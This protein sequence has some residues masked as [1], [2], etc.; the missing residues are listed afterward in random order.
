MA[1]GTRR[2]QHDSEL[3]SCYH[4]AFLPW[5]SYHNNIVLFY[6]DSPIT[7]S[8]FMDLT[9]RAIKSFY[10]ISGYCDCWHCHM[11]LLLKVL[12]VL[13]SKRYN[14]N[15]LL[16]VTSIHLL[17]VSWNIIPGQFPL[18]VSK[19]IKIVWLSSLTLNGKLVSVFL[20]KYKCDND[21]S[22]ELVFDVLSSCRGLD[23]SSRDDSAWISWKNIH[24][25]G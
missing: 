16:T 5:G 24:A 20:M 13:Q 17:L 1:P 18:P 3:T 7:R 9:D 19:A 23:E 4:K 22:C 6:H 15:I 8:H 11:T 12:S 25:G 2:P 10:C 21:V 14:T